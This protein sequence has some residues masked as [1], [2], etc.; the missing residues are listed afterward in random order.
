MANGP[1]LRYSRIE[2]IDVISEALTR[3]IDDKEAKFKTR[4]LAI[5]AQAKIPTVKTKMVK[6]EIS[7][8]NKVVQSGTVD[9]DRR[10]D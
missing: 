7:Q 10:N 3:L 4:L 9:V 2:H 1:E 8:K 6:Y 5:E